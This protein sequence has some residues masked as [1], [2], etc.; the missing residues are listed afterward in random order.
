MLASSFSVLLTNTVLL[1]IPVLWVKLFEKK[2]NLVKELGLSSRNLKQDVFWGLVGF[3][4]L[5]FLVFVPGNLIDAF[6][7][8]DSSYVVETV[9]AQPF[10]IIALILIVQVPVEELFFRGFLVNRVGIL[11][12]ALVFGL[13]HFS[14][15]SMSEVILAGLAGVVL[16]IIFSKR[17]NIFASIISH[18]LLNVMT[19][20][21]IYSNFSLVGGLS[22]LA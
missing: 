11:P 18:E 3:L 22:C 12:S 16:G 15:G 5:V 19:L 13:A 8:G 6:F 4:A 21:M 2:K 17:K 20:V 10:Y 9:K 14:Y 7:N 1:L